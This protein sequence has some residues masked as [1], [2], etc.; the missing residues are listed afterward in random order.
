MKTLSLVKNLAI[1]EEKVHFNLQKQ[2]LKNLKSIICTVLNS[3]SEISNQSKEQRYVVIS[4]YQYGTH[5]MRLSLRNLLCLLT[6]L[7]A[8][9]Q[10]S[11]AFSAEQMQVKIIPLAYISSERY[12]V[13]LCKNLLH[14]RLDLC[15]HFAQIGFL[16]IDAAGIFR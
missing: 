2:Y 6:H 8:M 5:I 1:I 16:L 9:G 13:H 14:K 7:M 11:I 3:R 15:F 4:K 12:L 10:L